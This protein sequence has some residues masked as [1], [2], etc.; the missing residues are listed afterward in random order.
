MLKFSVLMSVYKNEKPEYLKQALE[1]IVKQTLLPNEI[2]VIKDGLLTEE[3]DQVIEDYQD[4]Y[5]CLFKIVAFHENRGLG[6]ALRDGVIACSYEYI[7]RM[8]SDDVCKLNRFERQIEYLEKHR[9][10]A[11]LG[12]CIEE[13]N[14][15]VNKPDRIL[16]LPQKHKAIVDF[17]KSRNP[18]KHNTVIFKKSAVLKSGNYRHFRWFEDYDLWVRMIRNGFKVSNLPAV[19]VS[20]RMDDAVFSRRG[21]LNY[22]KWEWKFQLFLLGIDYIGLCQ[23]FKNI[24]IRTIVR[25]L[26]NRLRSKFYRCFLRRGVNNA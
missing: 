1:S 6:L 8:D 11:L 21:G 7:A 13:F 25:L 23:F 16:L 20:T 24:I 17:S 15:D 12:T 2:V 9:E 19:L 10:I 4:N 5:K 18:F 3:L 26:P 22:L 14:S